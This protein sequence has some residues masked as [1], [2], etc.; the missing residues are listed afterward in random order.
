MKNIIVA[1][2]MV[3]GLCAGAASAA[4]F[5]GGYFDLGYSSFTDSDDGSKFYGAASGELGF[6]RNFGIQ[7]DLGVYRYREIEETGYNGTLHFIYHTN[8]NLSLGAYYNRDDLDGDNDANTY[9]IEAGY[10]I[11]A[12]G[13]E[14]YVS[15]IDFVDAGDADGTLL[16]FKLDSEVAPLF[17]LSASVDY[18]DASGDVDLT[19]Y[20]VGADYNLGSGAHIYGELGGARA[21]VDS[22][23]RTEAYIAAGLRINF[24]SERGT[25]FGRRGLL[26]KL[27]GL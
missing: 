22:F 24:G 9:G 19:R 13:L 1:G 6:T 2:A 17:T 11:G 4:E 5:T 3:S 12:I 15:R 10:E 23:S 25:T 8:D 18:L 20:S 16:G 7:A 27:P 14:G 21:G 26:D